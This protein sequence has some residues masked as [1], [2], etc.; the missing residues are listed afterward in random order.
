V[1]ERPLWADA[2]G[3]Y[4]EVAATMRRRGDH[5]IWLERHTGALARALEAA[6]NELD[7][8]PQ[9]GL[10]DRGRGLV[11]RLAPGRTINLREYAKDAGVGLRV[12]RRDLSA[13]ARAGELVEMPGGGGL[14]FLRPTPPA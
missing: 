6:A 1:L 10:P 4:A 8:Q 9:P 5:S 13:F 7:P 12:A 2:T 11:D 3:Y 14:T